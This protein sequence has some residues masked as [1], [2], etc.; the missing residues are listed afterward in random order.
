MLEHGV[1]DMREG[2]GGAFLQVSGLKYSYRDKEV[3]SVFLSES[4]VRQ[5][6]ERRRLVTLSAGNPYETEICALPETETHGASLVDEALYLV[7]V[8]DWLASGGDGY[9]DIISSADAITTNTTLRE[10]ILEHARSLPFVSAGLRSESAN[11]KLTASAKQGLSGFVGGA[12][13]FLSTYPLYTLFVQRSASGKISLSFRDLFSGALL[14]MLA[15]ALSQSIYFVV[16]GSPTL[17]EFS[18]FMRS[19]VAA[20]TN[21]LLTTP[22]WVIITHLQVEESSMSTLAV[23]GHIYETSGVFGFFTGFSMNMVMC[24]VPVVRQVSFKA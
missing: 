15:T 8:T 16:Y 3:E 10:S 23:A 21:S 24:A 7:V 14:G 19:S 12:I 2:Q 13:S 6:N 22:L 20:T 11:A 17:A 4:N 18:P 1:K 9:G 5:P